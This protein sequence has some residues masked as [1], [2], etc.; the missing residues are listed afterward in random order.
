MGWLDVF[1]WILAQSSPQYEFVMML[2]PV[3]S[4]HFVLLW[5]LSCHYD[6]LGRKEVFD[7]Q[8]QRLVDGPFLS[9]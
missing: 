8:F 5:F 9:W 4:Y 6:T 2:S 3:L 7:T 1:M